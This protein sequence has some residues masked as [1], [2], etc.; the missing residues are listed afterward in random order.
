MSP[1]E[2]LV[3]MR[4]AGWRCAL[5]LAR[6]ERVLSAAMPVRVPRG[7]GASFVVRLGETL[8]PVVF[9]AALFGAAGVE[10]RLADKMVVLRLPRGECVL[11]V[12]AVEDLAPYVPLGNAAPAPAGGEYVAC[13]SGGDESLAVLDLDRVVSLVA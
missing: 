13:F 2:L 12:E 11:W 5:P 3:V 6:V 7:E 8:A 10:L 9:A 4:V 1:G